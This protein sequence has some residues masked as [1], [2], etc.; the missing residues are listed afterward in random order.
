[1]M[2][3]GAIQKEEDEGGEE[4]EEEEREGEENGRR[5]RRGYWVLDRLVLLL[6]IY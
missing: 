3:D 2:N 6:F 1:M 5:D 4:E